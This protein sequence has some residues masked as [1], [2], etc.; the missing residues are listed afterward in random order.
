MYPLARIILLLAL[1]SFCESQAFAQRS[2]STRV[3]RWYIPQFVPVQFAGNIGVISTGLGYS[4]RLRNYHLS[5]VY[6]YVPRSI[7]GTRIH[8][9]A[10]RNS[11]PIAR[12]SLNNNQVLIP[13]LG[14][15]LSFEIGGN[16]F[17]R[18]PDHFPKSYYDFPK[19]M[20]L[21]AY[22]GAKVQHLFDRT[23]SRF[24]GV[25]FFAEAGTIDVYLWYK[26]M[27]PDIR[28]YEI[29]SIALGANVL[30]RN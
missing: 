28:F 10:A 2:D 26:T 5:L 11:F 7:G 19:N 9:I 22:G 21:L 24:R 27:S 3:R 17:F 23:S 1:W 14:V 6:G 8:T 20:H 13:Y 18:Q 29:F 12:Y 25:E 16:S 15:G 30:L 4:S